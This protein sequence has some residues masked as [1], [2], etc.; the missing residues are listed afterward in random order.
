M[1]RGYA[2]GAGVLRSVPAW[3]CAHGWNFPIYWPTP[4][5]IEQVS[6]SAKHRVWV[7]LT[8]ASRHCCSWGHCYSWESLE[9]H[10]R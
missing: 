6:P 7:A 10:G 1:V 8:F 2:L 3:D 9:R 5:V 4:Q